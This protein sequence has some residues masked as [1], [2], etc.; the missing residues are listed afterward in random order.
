VLNTIASAVGVRKADGTL[1]DD[2]GDP[3][4][5]RGVLSTVL[6]AT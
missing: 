3:S 2:F 4:L 5:T 1:L 6:T